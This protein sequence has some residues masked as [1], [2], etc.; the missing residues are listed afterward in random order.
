MNQHFKFY[1][2]KEV[3]RVLVALVGSSYLC[4]SQHK[5]KYNI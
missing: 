1:Q 4:L 5:D 2:Q 3:G